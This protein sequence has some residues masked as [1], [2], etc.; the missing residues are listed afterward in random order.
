MGMALAMQPN[1]MQQISRIQT[2]LPASGVSSIMTEPVD[3]KQEWTLVA[4]KIGYGIF[5]RSK[6]SSLSTIKITYNA[7]GNREFRLVNTVKGC[8]KRFYF[9]NGGKVRDLVGQQQSVLALTA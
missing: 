4:Q 3:E 6:H 2:D 1:A 8:N 9:S 5:G 7:D